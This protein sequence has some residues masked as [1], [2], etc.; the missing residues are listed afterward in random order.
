MSQL[1]DFLVRWMHAA[2]PELID[3]FMLI[4]AYG[5]VLLVLR[6]FGLMGL[7]AFTVLAVV[8]AN[9]QV[10]KTVQYNILPQ[11]LAL[12]TI[13][14]S[15]SFLAIDLIT[16]YFGAATARRTIWLGFCCLLLHN[17][18]MLLTLGYRPLGTPDADGV[19][20]ALST[21]V[22]PQPGLL[23]AGLIAYLVSQHLDVWLYSR[24][25][26]A[27]QGKYLWLRNIAATAPAVLIDNTIFS[28]LAWQVF[29]AKP[30]SVEALIFTYILG[31]F[32]I[33]MLIT[34]LD[35]P[36]MYISRWAAKPHV[37]QTAPA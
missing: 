25:K 18:F 34:L 23:A 14:F 30:V 7:V 17:L 19:E 37:Q 31:T 16:E 4:A 13:L 36:F 27:T 35:T 2:P 32:F 10:L 6:Q 29:A 8:G 28:V 3:A 24:M 5:G 1:V 15:S 33:R 12:G 26:R 21:L 11:P 9:I 22:T 20:T